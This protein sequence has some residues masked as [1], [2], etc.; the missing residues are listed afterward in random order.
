ML[1][2][3]NPAT[4]SRE[5]PAVTLS[6]FRF[7]TTLLAVLA[8]V[9]Q[10]AACEQ[11][12]KVLGLS[13]EA[14]DEFSVYSRAPLSLPPEYSLRPPEPGAPRPQEGDTTMQAKAAL[15]SSSTVHQQG[16]SVQSPGLQALL[17]ATGATSADPGIRKLVNAESSGL[18]T[19]EDK[20]VSKILFWQK[21]KEPGTV[22]D[23]AKESERIKQVQSLGKPINEGE[24]PIIERG[25]KGLFR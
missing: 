23:A 1:V 13:K 8:L 5:A 4:P 19:D 7:S 6:F 9:S 18:A 10:L 25:K 16:A 17:R 24:T 2:R 15:L 12:R 22:V 21:S 20:L 3:V 11:S 14:P